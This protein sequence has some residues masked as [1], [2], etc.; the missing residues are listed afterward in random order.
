MNEVPV[1]LLMQN[2]SIHMKR[3]YFPSTF[4]RSRRYRG[5]NCI[6]CTL[7]EFEKNSKK[8]RFISYLNELQRTE[9]TSHIVIEKR[10]T[11]QR[12][13]GMSKT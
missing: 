12:A 9:A 4:P 7:N 11:L 3:F 10:E 6:L 5:C 1:L 13:V 8:L 2:Q